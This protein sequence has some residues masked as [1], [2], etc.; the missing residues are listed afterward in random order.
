MTPTTPRILPHRRA[1]ALS[2]PPWRIIITEHYLQS[3]AQIRVSRADL[4]LSP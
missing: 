1:A 4:F 2:S 3:E